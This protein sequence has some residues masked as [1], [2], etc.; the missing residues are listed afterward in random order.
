[1]RPNQWDYLMSDY[2]LNSLSETKFS[3]TDY[4]QITLKQQGI[5]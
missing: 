2:F 3:L 4:G 5:F 1:M